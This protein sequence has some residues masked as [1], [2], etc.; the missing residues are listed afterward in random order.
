MAAYF[1]N[2]QNSDSVVHDGST[3]EKAFSA[4]E[5]AILLNYGTVNGVFLIASDVLKCKGAWI[6]C[7]FLSGTLGC[8]GLTIESWGLEEFGPWYI[9]MAEDTPGVSD[10]PI[11]MRRG[12]IRDG[13]LVSP[14]CSQ[15]NIAYA[16]NCLISLRSNSTGS[17]SLVILGAIEG[18]YLI[19]MGTS[20]LNF[21]FEGST[22]ETDL[23]IK[24]TIVVVE[25]PFDDIFSSGGKLY[26]NYSTW[27]RT[28]G[29][30][31][32]SGWSGNAILGNI[33]YTFD[34]AAPVDAD[35]PYI[36][37]N[38]LI[39]SVAEFYQ[40]MSYAEV[41]PN[42]N[43]TLIE[44]ISN[45]ETGIMGLPRK[46]EM[47]ERVPPVTGVGG[48]FLQQSGITESNLGSMGGTL[49]Y[50]HED[51]HKFIRNA[52]SVLNSITT[53][54]LSVSSSGAGFKKSNASSIT[55]SHVAGNV[56]LV[57]NISFICWARNGNLRNGNNDS[58]YLMRIANDGTGVT[59]SL[60]IGFQSIDKMVI[61][62]AKA[63][64]V[65]A[66]SYEDTSW[67]LFGFTVNAL[68]L[69]EFS[70]DGVQKPTDVL[71]SDP[72]VT[73]SAGRIGGNPTDVFMCPMFGEDSTYYAFGKMEIA[74][75]RFSVKGQLSLASILA[76]YANELGTLPA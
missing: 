38:K 15:C 24:N 7:T 69:T 16:Y 58:C 43:M 66:S 21:G 30:W 17:S 42:V 29:N 37:A 2:F 52:G 68:G 44:S 4:D 47:S 73:A 63:T 51:N 23:N 10:F 48:C 55:L 41:P 46:Q 22:L 61:G 28:I 72:T 71:N 25:Q 57:K 18:C 75:P 76:T 3:H 5:F 62:D 54:G 53:Y 56:Y 11:R 34:W 26:S 9:K 1:I 60:I 35:L 31:Q 40:N 27:N 36:G 64:I 14:Y 49:V 67:H 19:A 6:D 45:Y 50:D 20:W 39:S 74:Y 33:T 65:P 59:G 70:I 12:T 8:L 32:G 13:I